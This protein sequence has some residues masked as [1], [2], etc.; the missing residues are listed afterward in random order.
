MEDHGA[1][2]VVL[3]S[4][5]EEQIR[6]DRDELFER[7]EQGTESFAE[8]LTY[9]PEISDGGLGPDERLDHI[10]KAKKALSIPV[11]ASLNGSSLGGWTDY[12][13]QIQ[14]AGRTRWN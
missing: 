10:A 9:F 2:A 7:T 8:A 11:I 5:F 12:A 4:L 1:S 13:R 14:E 3:H 6:R